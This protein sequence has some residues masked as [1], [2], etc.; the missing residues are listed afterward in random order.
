[1]IGE[2][3][4]DNI[5]MTQQGYNNILSQLETLKARRQTIAKAIGFA[6][7]KGDLK[8]NAEYHAAREEQG[9]NEAK[10]RDLESKLARAM[11]VKPE[12]SDCVTIGSYVT[13]LDL[14][15]DF[16]EEFQIVGAGEEDYTKNKILSTSPIGTALLSK[17]PDDTVEIEV[18][19]GTLRL[20]ILTVE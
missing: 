13:V 6:R 14:D 16:E 18:P 17:K 11:I 8:E 2:V 9:L 12:K 3:M 1:M 20:K 10:I 19:A 7:E 15:D 4:S 5:P